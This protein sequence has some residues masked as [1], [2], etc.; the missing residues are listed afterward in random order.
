MASMASGP[1]SVHLY[2]A[3]NHACKEY[4]VQ[5][6][7]SSELGL[8]IQGLELRNQYPLLLQVKRNSQN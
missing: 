3:I 5:L 8:V 1:R 7:K 6:L 2:E 4:P